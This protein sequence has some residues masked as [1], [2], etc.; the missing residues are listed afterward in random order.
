MTCHTEPASR[1]PDFAKSGSPSERRKIGG[2]H[3]AVKR[4]GICLFL[5]WLAAIVAANIASE[6]Q[7]ISWQPTTKNRL[8]NYK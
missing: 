7:E 5:R 6:Q 3:E 8:T 4:G 1:S 2:Q